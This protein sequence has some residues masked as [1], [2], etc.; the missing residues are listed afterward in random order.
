MAAELLQND[1][2]LE[3]EFEM[4]EIVTEEQIK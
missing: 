3:K 2:E 1:P 4:I